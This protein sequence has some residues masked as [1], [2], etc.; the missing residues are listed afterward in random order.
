MKKAARRILATA[1][2]KGRMHDFALFKQ[3]Q[4]PLQEETECLCDS[5]YTGIDK[6][7]EKA[8]TPHKKSKHHPLTPEQKRHNRELAR[9]RLVAEHVINW[10]KRFRILCGPYRN[11]RQRFGLRFNLIAAIYNAHLDL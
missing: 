4:L 6:Q 9:E 3:S 7:H 11:R 8:R 2:G 5:G 1:F 10:L